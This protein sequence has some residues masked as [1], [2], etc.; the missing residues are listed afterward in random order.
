MNGTFEA[1]DDFRDDKTG[2]CFGFF[3]FL[4]GQNQFDPVGATSGAKPPRR[5]RRTENINMSS[6]SKTA[7]LQ[8]WLVKDHLGYN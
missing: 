6:K 8:K 1:R 7:E 2:C 3:F 5:K 4:N